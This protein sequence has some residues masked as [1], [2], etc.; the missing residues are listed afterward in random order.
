MKAHKINHRHLLGLFVTL[1][2]CLSISPSVVSQTEKLGIV[3]YTPPKGWDKTVKENIVAFSNLDAATGHFCIITLYGATNSTGNPESDFKREW[4]NLVIKPFKAEAN[5]ET[6]TEVSD[7]WTAIAGG[8]AVELETGKAAAFLTVI[9]GG[10]KTVSILGLFNDQSYAGHLA[11]F[12]T[13]IDLG[14]VV[15][16]SPAPRREESA[17]PASST[18][19]T[20]MHAAA[21][22]G[23][24]ESNEVRANQVYIGKRVRIHGTVNTIEIG[25]DGRVVLT[26]KSSITTRNNAR[27]FFSQSQN[28][29]VATLSAHTVATVEGTVRGMGGGFDDSKAFVLL[30]N[31]IVP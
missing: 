1:I 25:K 14:K 5:P 28:S 19:I 29:G 30:D 16:E 23:E 9:S 3:K 6:E 13:G 17:P 7:G 11:A 22:V 8:T 21:L 27:C 18:D 15:A 2:L 10:G 24:F 26:F 31:C 4:N 12:G 20:S